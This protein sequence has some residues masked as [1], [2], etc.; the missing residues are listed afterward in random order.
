MG[1]LG[2]LLALE[3]RKGRNEALDRGYGRCNDNA[4]VCVAVTGPVQAKVPGPNGQI[5]FERLIQ[6]Q[7]D[8]T[9]LANVYT[10]NP[11]GTHVQ[12]VPLV[13]PPE[14][15]SFPVWSPDGTKLLISHTFRLDSEGNCCL[16]FR[17]AIVNPDGSGFTLLTMTYAP[18]DTDCPVWS[19]DQ[20]RILCGF[21]GDQPG[22]FSFNA[23]DGGDP[24]RLTTN[25]YGNVDRPTDISPDGTQF[26]FVRFKPRGQRP[27][28]AFGAV[29]GEY[30]WH[31]APADHPLWPHARTRLPLGRMVPGREQDHLGDYPR[32]AVHRPTRRL[33]TEGDSPTDRD[34]RL[35]RIGAPLVAGRHEDRLHHVPIKDGRGDLHCEARRVGRG[36]SHE[37]ADIG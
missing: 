13:Y 19:L 1:G 18:F 21:G 24:V 28:E 6:D 3:E 25:P 32:A 35:P 16:P 37:C 17:P 27:S 29:R 12:Q 10:T 8:D 31:R 34:W 2:Q 36:P 22:V 20:T 23:S 11:D 33:G 4:P 7:P 30:R 15:F 9:A 14:I 26:V 5:V